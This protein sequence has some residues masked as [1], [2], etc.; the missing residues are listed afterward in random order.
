M[1][2]A[3]IPEEAC[4]VFDFTLNHALKEIFDD[5]RN[6]NVDE[7]SLEK[8][9]G[10]FVRFLRPYPMTEAPMNR[11]GAEEILQRVMSGTTATMLARKAAVGSCR[12]CR[13]RCSLAR[14]G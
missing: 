11:M 5:S 3:E 1:G 12:Q 10:K 7:S 14:P 13:Q 6:P 4:H 9:V 2:K 8:K